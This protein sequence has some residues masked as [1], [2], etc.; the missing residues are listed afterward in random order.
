[1]GGRSFL[2]TSLELR[3]RLTDN[4]EVVGFIDSGLAYSNIIPLSEQKL[5]HGAGFGFRYIT[6]F[7]PIRAD[8]G[9]P[10]KRRKFIDDAFQLYFG[11]G[12]AF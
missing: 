8:I 9:F 2:E 5:L 6:D 1:M 3:L 4:I 10:L 11:I 7:G 12:Q